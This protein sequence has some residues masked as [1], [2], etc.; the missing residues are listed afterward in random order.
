MR[1]VF[2]DP[3][4]DWATLG[5]VIAAALVAGIGVTAA[6]SIAVLGATRSVE[7]RR[8]QRGLE[9]GAFAVLAVLGAAVCVGAIVG[10]IVV[11]SQK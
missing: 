1:T 4:V 3:V 8:S 11:M 5:K 2:A 7:M 9:S 10:G 6:F